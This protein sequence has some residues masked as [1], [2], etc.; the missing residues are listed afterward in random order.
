M[1]KIFDLRCLKRFKKDM[2]SEEYEPCCFHGV[3]N[4]LMN[5][6]AEAI[7]VNMENIKNDL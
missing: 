4:V 2:K 7:G 6:Q 1:V 3:S 5:I